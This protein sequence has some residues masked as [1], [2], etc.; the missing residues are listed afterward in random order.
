MPYASKPENA[1]CQKISTTLNCH[2][3]K[4]LPEDVAA[5]RKMAKRRCNMYF[6][7][8]IVRLNGTCQETEG[9]IKET[10]TSMRRQ[11][12][13][14]FL[15]PQGKNAQQPTEDIC[16]FVN[17]SRAGSGLSL[18]LD[19]THSHPSQIDELFK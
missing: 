8:H 15:R 7:Y 19:K 14:R 5:P 11:D 10:L 16:S 17:K 12:K 2:S 6:G 4:K 9:L 18:R 3:Y 1:P 13:S